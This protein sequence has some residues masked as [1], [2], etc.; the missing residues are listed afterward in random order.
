MEDER[1]HGLAASDLGGVELPA[2]ARFAM[3]L[4][5]RVMTTTAYYV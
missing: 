4:A 5:A 3:K 2:P 1:R